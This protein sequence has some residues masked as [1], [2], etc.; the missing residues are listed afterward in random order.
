MEKLKMSFP[1]AM[2]HYFGPRPDVE[3]SAAEFLK[4]LKAL[5]PEDKTAFREM[6]ATVG[7]ELT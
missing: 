5:T 2:R 7:Y 1:Q 3:P 4:E 6:L